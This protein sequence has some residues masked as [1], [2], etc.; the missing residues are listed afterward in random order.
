[1]VVDL[2]MTNQQKVDRMMFLLDQKDFM[3]EYSK[4]EKADAMDLIQELR[5]KVKE[6]TLRSL[7]QATKIRKSGGPNWKNLCEYVLCG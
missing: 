5:D 2:T 4:P 6:L 7:I 1:M 3:E